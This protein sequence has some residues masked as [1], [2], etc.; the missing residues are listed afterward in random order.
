MTEAYEIL[1]RRAAAQWA[2]LHA[3]PWVRVG[4]GLM[5][6]AAGAVETLAALR[7]AIADAGIEAAVSE[8]GTTGL[9]YA[10]PIV[11]VY[12]PGGPRVMYGNVGPEQVAAIVERHIVN[13][14]PV[15]ELALAS[16]DVD[17]PGIPRLEDL[18]MMQHQV[19]IALRN[20]GRSTRRTWIITSR[21]EASQGSTRRSRR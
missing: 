17:V 4:T 15:P 12:V 8:V 5:G 21:A 6:M 1:E 18:P 10:E 16:V 9:C 2:E 19:R 14:E 20:A 7:Q 11:D 13:G 3:K